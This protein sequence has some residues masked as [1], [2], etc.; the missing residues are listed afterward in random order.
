M[1]T[2]KKNETLTRVGRGTPMGELMRRYWLPFLLS[3]DLRDPDGEPRRVR[4]LGEDL[5]AFRDTGGRVGLLEKYCPHRCADLF[6]GRNEEYGLT[7]IYHG[8]KFDVTGQCVDMPS[9]PPGHSFAEK[10]RVPAYPVQERAGVLWTYMG[11][12]ELEPELPEFEWA[13]AP[14]DH[15]YASWNYQECNFVQAIEGGIDT[16]HS[17]FVHSTLDSH[18]KLDAQKEQGKRQGDPQMRYR[19]RDNAAKLFAQN[20]DYGVAI[21]AQYKGEGED[22]W[23]F[24]LFW[25][26]F[27][28]SPS[29]RPGVKMV[30]AF[31][32]LDDELTARWCFSCRL[33]RPYRSSEYAQ[34]RKG[35]GVHAELIAGT[36]WP[37]HNKRNNYLQDREM[38]RTESYSGIKDFGAQDYA[39]QEGMGPIQDRTIEHLGTSDIGIIAMRERLLEA[40]ADLQE[41][42]EPYTATHGD[43]Y[44]V[45]AGDVVLPPDA[46]WDEDERVKKVMA[47]RW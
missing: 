39:V 47:A 26:P 10:I 4:L 3:S 21:A 6:V 7:C 37:T 23:R 38:Q 43:V 30:H 42:T 35:S 32:P 31:V 20:T 45:H 44:H 15:R 33:D 40:A 8:W 2:V 41:G 14:D 13:R 29:G 46:K 1:L 12:K 18:R 36:H 11:P 17:I 25:M 5:V 27:Y 34:M 22:Y 24:N 28:T 19:T 9:E 16:I